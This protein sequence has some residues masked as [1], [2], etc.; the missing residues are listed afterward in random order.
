MQ[1][2][3]RRHIKEKLSKENYTLLLSLSSPSKIQD[4]L[5]SIP[6][7]HED[8]GETC[9][10][11]NRTLKESRAHCVEGALVAYAALTLLDY[12]PFLISLNVTDDDYDHVIT[13]YKK[14][15]YFGAISKTN[16]SV[17]GWRDP[18]Y[19]TVRELVMS[20]FHEY[21]L[22]KNGKKTMRS[23]SKPFYLSSSSFPWIDGEEE[24]FPLA[25]AIKDHPLSLI[26]PDIKTMSLRKASKL[27]Q[28]TSH[29]SWDDI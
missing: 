18:V 9:M 15:N 11:V 22:S 2:K 26:H 3:L 16:H 23:Y 29:I 5:E 10:S 13:V 21:F 4:Y 12:K 8:E 27:E 25:Y 14:E 6:F 1:I 28:K 20:Y 24:L 19:T 7:N 17:L